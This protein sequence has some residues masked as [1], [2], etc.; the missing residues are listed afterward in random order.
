MLA[1]YLAFV[2][3]LP[4]PPPKPVKVKQKTSRRG[5]KKAR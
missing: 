1:F 3:E 2:A 4:P 5:R